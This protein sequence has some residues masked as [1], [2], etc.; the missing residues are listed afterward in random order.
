MYKQAIYVKNNGRKAGERVIFGLSCRRGFKKCVGESEIS[1]VK[2]INFSNSKIAGALSGKGFYI[3]LCVCV[4][5]VGAAGAA[6]YRNTV[7]ELTQNPAFTEQT[8]SFTEQDASDVDS[9]L[10]GILKSDTTEAAVTEPI[11][12]DLEALLNA[13]P[14]VMPVNGEVINAFSHGELVKTEPLNIWKTHDGTDI[15]ADTGTEVKSMTSGTVT[16][17]WEDPLWGQCVIIDHGNAIEGHYYNLAKALTVKVGD[18]VNAGTVIGSVGDT[19]DIE[20]NME[21]HLHFAI[22]RAGNWIDPIDYIS[23]SK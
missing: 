6:V 20:A 10:S 18:E 17:V 19:A 8:T 15:K 2:K 12:P 21:P 14:N 16:Q 22:K 4:T 1:T 23:P 5:A 9:L 7:K 3:A 13:Q 11:E